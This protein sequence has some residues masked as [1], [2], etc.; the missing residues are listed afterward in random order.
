YE[1]GK[2]F[3]C[4]HKTLYIMLVN[5]YKYAIVSTNDMK[6][7]EFYL[8]SKSFNKENVIGFYVYTNYFLIVTVSAVE[9]VDAIS[10]KQLH[11]EKQN[12]NNKEI[13]MTYF[14]NNQITG[15]Y[16]GTIVEMIT[17]T[18]MIAINDE[19]EDAKNYR[20][21]MKLEITGDNNDKHMEIIEIYTS[22]NIA[23]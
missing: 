19:N 14:T 2:T 23:E 5:D 4:M 17:K 15:I 13:T 1:Y 22:K 6:N 16:M 18:E 12:R 7:F 3:F 11:I 8:S 21:V 9:Y 10:G 20:L